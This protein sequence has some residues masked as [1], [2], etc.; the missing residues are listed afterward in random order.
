M[1]AGA[2]HAVVWE[3]G[4]LIDLGSGPM[5]DAAAVA[6]NENGDVLGI[7]GQC[8]RRPEG[9]CS[10]IGGEPTRA[11]LWRRLKPNQVA[12]Q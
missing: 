2:Q 6:I 4:Q 8:W 11:I 5:S 10:A 12:Q 1:P 3:N 7:S 9:G